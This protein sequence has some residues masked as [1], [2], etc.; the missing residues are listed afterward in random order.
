M[1]F[2]LFQADRRLGMVHGN[3]RVWRE[4]GRDLQRQVGIN[5]V[6]EAG[7]EDAEDAEADEDAGDG[8]GGPV[9]VRFEASPAEPVQV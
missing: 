2:L 1:F 4:S 3:G 8:G 7:E 5:K 6:V 9:D